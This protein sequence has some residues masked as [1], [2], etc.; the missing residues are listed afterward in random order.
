MRKFV[1]NVIKFCFQ[2][3]GLFVAT[4]CG[5]V[6]RPF[7]RKEL[8]W[9]VDPLTNVKYWSR[10]FS[11]AGV[12]SKSL[13]T[14]HYSIA[15]KSDYDLYFDDLLPKFIGGVWRQLLMPFGAFRYLLAHASVFHGFFSGGPLGRTPFA[16]LEPF[17]LKLAGIK[18]VI[19]PYGSDAYLYSK[20]AD[21]SLRHVLLSDYPDAGRN[22]KQIQRQVDRWNRYADVVIVGIMTEGVRWDCAPVSHI[23][24]DTAE[25]PP[26][27]R[28]SEADGINL[29]VR[30]MHAPNHRSFKGTEFLIKAVD[31]LRA[32]GLLIHLDLVER[33]TNVEVRERMTK[34]DIL[35]EQLIVRGYALTAME[36]MATGIPVVCNLTDSPMIRHLNTNSYLR[37]CPAISANPENI[38]EVLERLI[39]HPS[40]RAEI[41]RASRTYAE[42]YHSDAAARFLY[43]AVHDKIQNRRKVDLMNLFKPVNQ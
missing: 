7:V 12:L 39:R 23:T 25:W 9:G 28:Y 6:A 32:K 3:G 1:A 41:G 37:E 35:V 2:C 38:V 15:K 8:I 13:V 5:L 31:D 4:V 21:T 17:L 22:E 34:A 36:G 14:H 42:K 30:I 11:K 43:T 20:L 24:I 10:A 27:T 18:T 40:M 33:V 16:P 19:T 29:A 26:V